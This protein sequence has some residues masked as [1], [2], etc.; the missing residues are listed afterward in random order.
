M[1]LNGVKTEA[2]GQKMSKLRGQ[3]YGRYLTRKL[4]TSSFLK[5]GKPSKVKQKSWLNVLCM[6][7]KLKVAW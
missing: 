4:A 6:G 7:L 1:L 2:I 3:E 5:L